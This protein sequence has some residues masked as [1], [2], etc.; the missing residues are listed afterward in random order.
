MNNRVNITAIVQTALFA[1]LICVAAPLSIQIGPVPVTLA[2]FAVYIA[3]GVLERRRAVIAVVIYI[4]LGLIGLPVFAGFGAGPAKLFGVTGGYIFG[5]IPL[6]Y[7]VGGF[8]DMAKL[9]SAK[10]P[11][12]MLAGTL[13]L[14]TLGSV[15]YALSTGSGVTAT[16]LACVVPF[17]PGDFV[18]IVL[19]GTLIPSLRFVRGKFL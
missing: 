11:L 9:K 6:A 13:V 3:A 17:L 2:T 18:K 10:Y 12:G 14:Y 15:W 4:L 1:A 7:I 16:L 5:Y 19:A 8:S